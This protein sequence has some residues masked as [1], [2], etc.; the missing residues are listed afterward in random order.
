MQLTPALGQNLPISRRS[1]G[2][3]LF[4][5]LAHVCLCIC[6]QTGCSHTVTHA[7]I[8]ISVNAVHAYTATFDDGFFVDVDTPE[9]GFATA[10]PPQIE[11]SVRPLVNIYLTIKNV[12]LSTIEFSKLSLSLLLRRVLVLDVAGSA[13]LIPAPT[14]A[15]RPILAGIRHDTFLAPSE[16]WSGVLVLDY[17]TLADA[18]SVSITQQV[19]V[20]ALGKVRFKDG[21]FAKL[22]IDRPPYHSEKL[23]YGNVRLNTNQKTIIVRS[24]SNP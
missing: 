13:D 12:S 20:N 22:I 16:T 4:I 17:F 3:P 1:H 14:S 8:E 23:I 24:V 2:N 10:T 11:Y 7:D 19:S 21:E 5:W 6:L 15:R 9:G 18:G